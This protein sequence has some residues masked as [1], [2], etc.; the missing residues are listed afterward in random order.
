MTLSN[1][2]YMEEAFFKKTIVLK[3]RKVKILHLV[4]VISAAYSTWEQIVDF[5]TTT[6]FK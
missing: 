2:G 4:F 3:T 1:V 5:F 6:K